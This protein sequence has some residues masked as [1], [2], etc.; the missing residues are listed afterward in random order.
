MTI[1]A[2]VLVAIIASASVASDG[3]RDACS[4]LPLLKRYFESGVA[5]RFGAQQVRIRTSADL[6]TADCGAPDCYGTTLD[7]MVNLQPLEGRCEIKSARLSVESFAGAGCEHFEVGKNIEVI[8]LASSQPGVDL[9]QA[10]L[11]SL[12]FLERGGRRALLL[13]PLNLLYF[14]N[15]EPVGVLHDQLPVGSE[16]DCCWGASSSQMILGTMESSG[17]WGPFPG[18]IP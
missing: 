8:T 5:R 16:Q 15:V 14:D 12:T 3:R 13:K 7:L 9:G 4:E 11:D 17:P 1:T 18:A 2:A 6:H 10:S